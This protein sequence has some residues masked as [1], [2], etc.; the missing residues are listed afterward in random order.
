MRLYFT[1]SPDPEEAGLD[2]KPAKKVVLP[3]DVRLLDMCTEAA[4]KH[5]DEATYS[6]LQIQEAVQVPLDE[7]FP[8]FPSASASIAAAVEL[9]FSLQVRSRGRLARKQR[10]LPPC[11]PCAVVAAARPLCCPRFSRR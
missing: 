11:H 9:G 3:E 4:Y 1:P 5:L 10:V 7:L 8:D 6:A 2:G